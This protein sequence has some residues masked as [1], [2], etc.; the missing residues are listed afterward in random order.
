MTRTL[1]QV[2]Q[3]DG[4]E[5]CTGLMD[6]I[7]LDGCVIKHEQGE[8]SKKIAVALK[9]HNEA[10]RE[11]LKILTGP[12]GCVANIAEMNIRC[13]ARKA[14]NL[15]EPLQDHKTTSHCVESQTLQSKGKTTTWRYTI[16]RPHARWQWL[17][18][19]LQL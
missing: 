18:P 7:D 14:Q 17:C 5:I 2:Q 11:M 6:K 13:R 12:G 1:V 15:A 16:L 10:M 8:Q 3:D 19:I 4:K 9:D